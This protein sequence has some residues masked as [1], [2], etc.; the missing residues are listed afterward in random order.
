[1][2]RCAENRLESNQRNAKERV[3]KQKL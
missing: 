1:M 3:R 2:G